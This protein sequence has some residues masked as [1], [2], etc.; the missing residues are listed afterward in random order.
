MYTILKWLFQWLFIITACV[1]GAWWIVTLLLSFGD[2]GGFWL[3]PPAIILFGAPVIVG[4]ALLPLR[5]LLRWNRSRMKKMILVHL[6]AQGMSRD[7]LGP[8]V[9]SDEQPTAM[10]FYDQGQVILASAQG[11]RHIERYDIDE[12]RWREIRNKRGEYIGIEALP[13]AQRSKTGTLQ[14]LSGWKLPGEV[15]AIYGANGIPLP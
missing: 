15:R 2:P 8:V 13:S 14:V 11:E 12:L 6:D 5:L 7:L 9:S 4:L 1:A 10:A 3:G